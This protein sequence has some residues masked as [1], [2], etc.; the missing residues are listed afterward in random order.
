MGGPKPGDRNFLLVSHMGAGV[1][2]LGPFSSVFPGYKQGIGSGS[3]AARIGSSA[4]MGSWHHRQKLSIMPRCPLLWLTFNS[5]LLLLQVYSMP[6]M[7]RVQKYM[8]TKVFNV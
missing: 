6:V 5:V 8:C 3:G 4:L 7:A 1:Q 2:G